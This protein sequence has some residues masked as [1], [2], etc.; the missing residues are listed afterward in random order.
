MPNFSIALT[1]LQADSVALYQ[2]IGSSGSGDPVQVGVGTR[3]SGTAT[4]YT[5]GS[6]TTTTNSTD[7][8]LSGNGFFL[9]QNGNDQSLT[10]A[11]NFQVSN[12]GNLTTTDGENVMG[13]GMTNGVTNLNGGL[14]P[15]QLPVGLSEPAQMTQNVSLTTSLHA[16]SAPGAR[17]ATPSAPSRSASLRSC[18]AR[19]ANTCSKLGAASMT[20]RSCRLNRVW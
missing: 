7:M 16:A 2:T 12:S 18:R 1:G 13:Y 10:R 14:I 5:Q 6:L 8:A 3:V 20:R 9:V 15:L 4:N 11:G 19:Q 17:P